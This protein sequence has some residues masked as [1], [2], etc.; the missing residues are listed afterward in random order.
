MKKITFFL[1]ALFIVPLYSLA[2]DVSEHVRE[3]GLNLHSTSNFGIRFKCGNNKTL[4]RLTVNSLN[5]SETHQ[6]GSSYSKSKS[7]GAGINFGIE[8]RKLISDN[9]YFYYGSDILASYNKSSNKL[10]GEGDNSDWTIAPGIGFVLGLVF[11]INSILN[12]SAEAMPSIWY[13]YNESTNSGIIFNKYT[14]KGI[15]YGLISPGANITFS[16]KFGQKN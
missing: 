11:N 5:G 8:R 4:L 12:V 15:N 3:I 13:S 2:Q 14:N 9:L 7:F 1:I 16:Y 6:N 10:N